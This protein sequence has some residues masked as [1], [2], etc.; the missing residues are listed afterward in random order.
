MVTILHAVGITLTEIVDYKL[1]LFKQISGT[2]ISLESAAKFVT[3]RIFESPH[4]F[5][6]ARNNFF[7]RKYLLKN[8]LPFL[9]IGIVLK[10]IK[11]IDLP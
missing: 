2:F 6:S 8:F 11:L 1:V 7:V 10:L 3:T 5:N 4:I 9:D